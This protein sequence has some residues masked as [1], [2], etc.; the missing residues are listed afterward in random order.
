[1]ANVYYKIDGDNCYYTNENKSG[2][3]LRPEGSQTIPG[4]KNVIIELYNNKFVFPGDARYLFMKATNTA[5]NDIDKWDTSSCY[6]MSH[7]FAVCNNVVSL[8]LSSFNTSNVVSMSY[9]FLT[10]KLSS[11]NISSFNTSRVTDMSG[12]FSNCGSLKSLNLSHF[13]VS[14]VTNMNSMFDSVSSVTSLDLVKWNTSKLSNASYMFYNCRSLKTIYVDNSWSSISLSNYM[15]LNCISL[16]GGAGTRYNSGKITAE[17]A[18]INTADTPGYFTKGH[19]W[20]QQNVYL[21]MSTD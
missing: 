16:V 2:Y 11:L 15:F 4:S 19:N 5:F 9:M 7:L 20:I 8:D 12:M 13:D 6:N 3:T 18:V 14:N 1:M 10:G 21:K 17:Y